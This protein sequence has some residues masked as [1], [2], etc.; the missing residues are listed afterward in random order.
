MRLVSPNNDSSQL[1]ALKRMQK[2][3]IVE[4]EMQDFIKNEKEFLSEISSN[5]VLQ[6]IATG[7][8][9]D[10]VYLLVE[11]LPGGDLFSAVEQT[12]G[13]LPEKP[14]VQFVASYSS[15][16]G[17]YL[18]NSRNVEPMLGGPKLAPTMTMFSPPRVDIFL[19]ALID[20]TP[21]AC[22]MLLDPL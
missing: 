5:F 14:T 15:P 19:G 22:E 16:P 8:D 20:K 6:L 10:S 1:Y 11:F 21:I 3:L 9:Q 17:P 12:G 18:T 4:E 2:A 7:R 13:P